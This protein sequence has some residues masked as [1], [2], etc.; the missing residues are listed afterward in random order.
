MRGLSV[1]SQRKEGW[2]NEV[3]ISPKPEKRRLEK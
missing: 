2:I 3:I 1:L